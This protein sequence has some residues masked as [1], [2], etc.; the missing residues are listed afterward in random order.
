MVPSADDQTHCSLRVNKGSGGQIAQLQNIE[1]IQ[2]QAIARVLLMDVATTNE[3]RNPLAPPSDKQ[4]PQWKTRPSNGRAEEKARLILVV[5]PFSDSLTSQIPSDAPVHAPTASVPIPG[6]RYGFRLPTPTADSATS[7]GDS[8]VPHRS[9]SA[10]QSSHQSSTHP[11]SC[12]CSAT[13]ASRGRTPITMPTPP[14]PLRSLQIVQRAYNSQTRQLSRTVSVCDLNTAS[15]PQNFFDQDVSVPTPPP[16]YHA[17][18]DS[19]TECVDDHDSFPSQHGKFPISGDT[20]IDDISPNEDERMAEAALHTPDSRSQ[21]AKVNSVNS[22]ASTLELGQFYHG[23]DKQDSRALPATRPADSQIDPALLAI[24]EQHHGENPDVVHAYHQR[25]GF[26]HV[27]APE[28][29]HAIRNQQQ[30]SPGITVV[31]HQRCLAT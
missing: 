20:D 22:R 4:L 28:Q 12:G 26:P 11:T 13:P 9:V 30:P 23:E 5:L 31:M 25:N 17:G 6:S 21:G 2:T 8:T 29:L 19:D 10:I 1:C 15:Q 7:C 16:Y 14:I 18:E 3:P 24:S 27:P